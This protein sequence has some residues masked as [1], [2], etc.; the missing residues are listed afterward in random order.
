MLV[1]MVKCHV[2]VMVYVDLIMFPFLFDMSIQYCCLFLSLFQLKTCFILVI[3]FGMY[4]CLFVFV[5][6]FILFFL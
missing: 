3:F 6:L 4:V 5:S 1:G 2:M